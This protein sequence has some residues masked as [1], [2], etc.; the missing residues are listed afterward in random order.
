MKVEELGAYIREN[1]DRN[2]PINQ[3]PN[4]YAKN[5]YVEFIFQKIM[6]SK[7]H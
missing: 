6:E 7:G 2:R 4:L 3:K 5:Q 1:K